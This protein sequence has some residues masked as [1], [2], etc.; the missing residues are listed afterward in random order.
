MVH[1]FNGERTLSADRGWT[2]RNRLSWTL[3]FPSQ[4]LY[5]AADYGEIGGRGADLNLGTHLAGRAMG[6]R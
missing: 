3:P 2:I 5:I 1:G 6:L 4:E